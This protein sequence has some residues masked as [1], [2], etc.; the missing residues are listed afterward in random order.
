VLI[1]GT[2]PH[3]GSHHA[4]VIDGDEQVLGEVRVRA[5]CRQRERCWRS[6]C[7]SAMKANGVP[8][9]RR[10]NLITRCSR[11]RL[12]I[13]R[14]LWCR[15]NSVRSRT[16][17]SSS[18]R[19]HPRY[20]AAGQDVAARRLGRRNLRRGPPARFLHGRETLNARV[21]LLVAGWRQSTQIL[22][23]RRRG[24]KV[25]GS[26]DVIGC[27][28]LHVEQARS[29]R[30]RFVPRSDRRCDSAVWSAAIDRARGRGRRRPARGQR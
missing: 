3:K 12:R 26:C 7:R 8:Q 21:D 17:R 1:I 2:D 16:A 22:D 30:W 6:R 4:T 18:A 25:R 19:R 23:S 15:S 24:H 14:L 11:K 9:L 27:R 5:D 29:G 13:S 10:A 20:R 28:A